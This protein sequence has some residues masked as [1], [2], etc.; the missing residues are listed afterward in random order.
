LV[1]SG[2]PGFSPAVTINPNIGFKGRGKTQTFVIPSEARNLSFPGLPIEERF[3][4]SLGMT[5]NNFFRAC[6]SA[7]VEFG[8][9]AA[10]I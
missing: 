9:S 2:G 1:R 7:E 8:R 6:L 5:K 3:L 4:A 10:P